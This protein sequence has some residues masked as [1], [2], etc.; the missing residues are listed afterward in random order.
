MGFVFY[1]VRGLSR[2]TLLEITFFSIFV[3]FFIFILSPDFHQNWHSGMSTRLF[4]EVKQHWAML[5]LGVGP[6]R[7]TLITWQLAPVDQ[8]ALSA[9]F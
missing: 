2:L 7:C 1:L 9:L 4:T 3:V 6:F 8:N 5:V